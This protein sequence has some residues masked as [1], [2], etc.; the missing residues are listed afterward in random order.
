MINRLG[1]EFLDF[2]RWWRHRLWDVVPPRLRR[3]LSPDKPRIL[4]EWENDLPHFEGWIDGA[5]L[6]MEDAAD[7]TAAEVYAGASAMAGRSLS[8]RECAEILLLPPTVALERRVKLPRA[9]EN[10]L[11]QAVGYLIPEISPFRPD[12]IYYAARLVR[13]SRDG[14]SID[15]DV[16]LATRKAVDDYIDRLSERGFRPDIVTGPLDRGRLDGSLNLLPPTRGVTS[17]RGRKIGR[18]VLAGGAAAL[19]AACLYVPYEARE[20]Q[21]QAL[22][23]EIDLLE[24]RIEEARALTE[25]AAAKRGEYDQAASQMSGSVSQLDILAALTGLLTDETWLNAY[26][27]DGQTVSIG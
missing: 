23:A 9:A 3:R 10:N 20:A 11:R 14:P 5:R 8:P 1:S 27:S 26:R 16:L 18:A 13:G 12:D 21:I 6:P 19:F 24:P 4:I 17:R 7:T 25:R 2:L 15:V 22:R